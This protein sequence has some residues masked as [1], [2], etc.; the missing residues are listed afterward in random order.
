[1]GVAAAEGGV[2]LEQALLHV[3]AES[4]GLVVG[5][6]GPGVGVDL[7]RLVL[8][9]LVDL[10]VGIQH[11]VQGLALVFRRLGQHVRRPDVFHLEAL[12]EFHVLPE[13]GLA[14]ARR[15]DLLAPHLAATLGVAE[16]AF[17]FHPHGAG[18]DQ[19]GRHRRHR[20]IDVGH[21][22]EG[23]RVAPAR[24]DLAIDVGPGL[25]VVG[26]RGPV[27]TDLAVL[28]HAAL[29]HRVIAHLRGKRARRQLPELL[30]S[31]PDASD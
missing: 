29:R 15:L 25:H 14:V 2:F 23:L 24:I 1:V 3:V 11:L 26:G 16:H 28:Q 17:L 7:R 21:H 27:E 10:A 18:Q 6:A 22:D 20:R 13:V 30:R 19:V 5:V 9:E 4:L 8:G 31:S 12:G